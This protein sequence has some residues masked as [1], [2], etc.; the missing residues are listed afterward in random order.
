M[1][2]R[3]ES[4]PDH[5]APIES[6]RRLL[7][8]VERRL[9]S[10][11][12]L[13]PHRLPEGL[14][15]RD[16]ICR[17]AGGARLQIAT[18]CDRGPSC[19]TRVV[20]AEIVAPERGVAAMQLL[21]T[22]GRGAAGAGFLLGLRA[23]V[24]R[25]TILD[26]DAPLAGSGAAAVEPSLRRLADGLRAL[27][28]SLQPAPWRRPLASPLQLS[29]ALDAPPEPAQL[30]T[31]VDLLERPAGSHR[32]SRG[33]VSDAPRSRLVHAFAARLRGSL[34]LR[35]TFGGSW[36]DRYVDLAI[37]ALAPDALPV[38]RLGIRI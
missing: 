36:I 1:P 7:W 10:R 27:G 20:V 26:L 30:A 17:R 19:G 15:A 18:R 29:V 3:P 9:Q 21:A 34:L 38:D 28:R 33:F 23:V 13:Q 12:R 37:L 11:L 31:L 32:A 24:G 6:L 22:P 35:G 25:P 5:S 16:G 4:C 14:P 2:E 8:P